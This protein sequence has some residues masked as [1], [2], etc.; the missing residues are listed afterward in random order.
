MISVSQANHYRI[1]MLP[2]L[3]DVRM[4]GSTN[5]L[6]INPSFLLPTQDICQV[7]LINWLHTIKAN[8]P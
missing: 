7:S 6:P 5:Y 8:K 1:G 2:H 4:V 3:L